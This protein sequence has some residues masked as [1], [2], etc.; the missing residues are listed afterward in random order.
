MNQQNT[1]LS[2]IGSLFGKKSSRGAGNGEMQ[3]GDDTTQSLLEPRSTFLR[4]WARRD[5]AIEH[6]QNGFD[7]LTDLMGGIKD[8]LDKQSQRHS[9]LVNYLSHL[10][11]LAQ[12]LPE[13]NRVQGETLRAIQQQIESQG[14]RADRLS[15]IL[16]RMNTAGSEQGEMLHSLHERVESFRVQDQAIADNLS[17]VGSAMQSVSKNSTA[18]A[19]ILEQ[20]RDNTSSRDGQLERILHKQNVRFTTM[21]AIAIFLSVAALVTVSVLGYLLILKK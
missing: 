10:P 2:R 14:T 3:L 9:E 15:E 13:A 18:S 21:L 17:S 5:A 20:L 12:D 7:T 1:I 6:L 11:Q 8:H 4:P 19:Q 16:D